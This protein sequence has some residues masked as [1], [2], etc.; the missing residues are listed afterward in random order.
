MLTPRQMVRALERAGFTM[1]R[2]TGSH[3]IMR[4][5]VSKRKVTVPWHNRDLRRDLMFSII[6]QAGLTPGELAELL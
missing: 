1:E 6:R 5:P 4:H 3:A 2:Q